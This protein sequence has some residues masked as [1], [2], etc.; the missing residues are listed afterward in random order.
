MEDVLQIAVHA[1]LRLKMANGKLKLQQ[2]CIF[3]HQNVPAIDAKTA[4]THSRQTMMDKLDKL[5]CEAASHEGLADI[6]SF[7]QKEMTE[8]QMLCNDQLNNFIESNS[9]RDLMEQWRQS[10]SIQLGEHI[11]ELIRKGI[12]DIQTTKTLREAELMRTNKR[13]VHELELQEQAQALASQFKGQELSVQ[14][15]IETFNSMWKSGWVQLNKTLLIISNRS[16]K[17]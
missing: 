13:K 2:T 15:L 14:I 16:K 7:S 1:F 11:T 17:K 10:K 3:V 8:M 12:K 5:T 9:H 6:T 4:M